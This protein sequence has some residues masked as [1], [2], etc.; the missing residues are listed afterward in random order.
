MQYTQYIMYKVQNF[1]FT[2]KKRCLQNIVYKTFFM[3]A[4]YSSWVT[5]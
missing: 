2:L 1:D 3:T 5:K 4:F